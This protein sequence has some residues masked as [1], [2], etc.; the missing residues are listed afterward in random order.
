MQQSIDTIIELRRRTLRGAD[1]YCLA[2]DSQLIAQQCRI[3]QQPHWMVQ[4]WLQTA[5][6]QVASKGA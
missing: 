3:E 6:D 4:F 1:R 2:L 5:A